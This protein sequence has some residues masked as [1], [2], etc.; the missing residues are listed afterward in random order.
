MQGPSHAEAAPSAS[1]AS[2]PPLS[3]RPKTSAASSKAPQKA[4][5]QRIEAEDMSMLE[6]SE[7]ERE[8]ES[9]VAAPVQQPSGLS[10]AERKVRPLS[11]KGTG[12]SPF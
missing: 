2:D 12:L 1:Q 3:S 5:A 7:E 9:K 4:A 6:D 8:E 11:W 10:F